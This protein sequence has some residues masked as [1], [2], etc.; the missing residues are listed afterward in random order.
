MHCQQIVANSFMEQSN[1]YSVL[2]W[3][4]KSQNLNSRGHLC[5][6]E[7]KGDSNHEC[8]DNQCRIQ[9]DIMAAWTQISKASFQKIIKFMPR[10]TD[11]VLK[12]NSIK[13]YT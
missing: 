7:Q 10:R 11:M 8:A 9:N 6:Y 1:E 12:A 2:K 3:P 13:K 4:V 5:K